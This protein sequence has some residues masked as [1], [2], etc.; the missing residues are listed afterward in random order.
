MTD[1]GFAAFV[2]HTVIKYSMLHIEMTLEYK[3]SSACLRQPNGER[4]RILKIAEKRVLYLFFRHMPGVP[5]D[6]PKK[7]EKSE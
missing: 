4:Q 1:V 5:V 3:K 6:F 7:R 2:G